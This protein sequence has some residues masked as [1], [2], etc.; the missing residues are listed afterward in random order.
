MYN[1][2]LNLLAKDTRI[3]AREH[4]CDAIGLVLNQ[5]VWST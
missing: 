3:I 1:Q 5:N 4:V 2:Y